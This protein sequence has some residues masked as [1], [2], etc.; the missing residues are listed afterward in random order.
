M[1]EDAQGS[2][3]PIQNLVDKIASVFVPTVLVIALV[4]GASWLIWGPE[5]SG[6]N[7]L[8]TFVNVL[9]IACPCALGLATPTA[10]MVGLGI[11]A[12]QGILVKDAAALERFK[13]AQKL[14]VD[15]TGTLTIGKPIVTEMI[16]F[17]GK[18][19]D[20]DLLEI[21]YTAEERSNHPLANSIF[22]FLS[23]RDFGKVMLESYQNVPGKGVEVK[24]FGDLY[25]IGSRKFIE[26]L[27]VNFEAVEDSRPKD[28]GETL[29]FVANEESLLMA[30]VLEDEIKEEA[31][32]AVRHFQERNIQLHL[33]SGDRE[34]AVASVAESLG[35]ENFKAEVSPEDKAD[36]VKGLQEQGGEVAMVG[37]GINDAPALAKADVGISMG[38]GTD[39]AMES[40]GIV[41][42]K[43]DLSKLFRAYKLSILT[44]RSIRE[45]LFW[46]FIYN[47]ICIPIA[48]GILYPI[49]G[50]MLNPMIAGAAMAFSSVSVVLNSL[51]LRWRW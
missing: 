7:A 40:A 42:V 46:A 12:K 41:L 29:V 48:A 33:L 24:Y 13:K 27:E 30:F 39:I 18:E 38:D 47:V 28:Q 35:L 1:V 5:P 32:E 6:S 3:A 20:K 11:G 2:K 23:Q 45:N 50:F 17:T 49:N 4:S 22:R 43:G 19:A 25:R 51:R 9:I 36:Y 31:L 8:I 21:I 44:M 26:E 16:S 15:K 14:V 34:A 37:D 10:L